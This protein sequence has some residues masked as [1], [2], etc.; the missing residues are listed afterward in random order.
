MTTRTSLLLLLI[1]FLGGAAL[2]GWLASTEGLPWGTAPDSRI[3]ATQPAI[4]IDPLARIPA[5]PAASVAPAPLTGEAARTEAIVVVLAARRTVDSGTRLGPLEPRL[6]AA[7]GRIQ[8]VALATVLA[9]ARV[10]VTTTMLLGDFERI[11]PALKQQPGT[12]W[13]IARREAAN[14]FVLRSSESPLTG[15]E[16][17][18]AEARQLLVAGRVAEAARIVEAMPGAA[19]AGTWLAN[20]R[21][22][23]AMRK[24]LDALESAALAAPLPE[25]PP[26]APVAPPPQLFPP[27]P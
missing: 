16:A 5:A 25:T 12:A 10:P 17:Q 9:G 8:P 23:V 4:V 19:S 15:P 24:A 18:I 22:Y 26:P 27:T 14:L 11:A 20:A 2:V 6:T 21:R 13:D 7:F 1:A 3:A